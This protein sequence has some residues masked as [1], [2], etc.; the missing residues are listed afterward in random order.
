MARHVVSRRLT[1]VWRTAA[2]GAFRPLQ[3]IPAKVGSLNPKPAFDLGDG[4]YSSCPLADLGDY[5]YQ[6]VEQR[7]GILQIGGV[8]PLGE[9]AI[10]GNEQFARF[11]LATLIPAQLGEACHCAQL[12]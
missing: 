1:G 5:S 10:D 3:S 6:L 12:P 2:I 7:L 8:E 4:D 11:S 9:P